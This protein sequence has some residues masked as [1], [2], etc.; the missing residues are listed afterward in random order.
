MQLKD[1]T[2]GIFR[3]NARK[4]KKTDVLG[5]WHLLNT[6]FLKHE[7]WGSPLVQGENYQENPGDKRK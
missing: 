1:P 5:T 4:E 6:I 2:K 3:S 7:W